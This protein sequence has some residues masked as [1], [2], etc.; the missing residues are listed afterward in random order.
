MR[1]YIRGNML[2]ITS[3]DLTNCD[4][5][6][7]IGLGAHLGDLWYPTSADVSEPMVARRNGHRLDTLA[8]RM[9]VNSGFPGVWDG[10]AWNYCTN[11]VDCFMQG[12]LDRRRETK[13][14]NLKIT[15]TTCPPNF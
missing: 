6:G 13:I 7:K 1:G 2:K 8:K 14:R 15:D 12:H 10:Y 9:S 3:G 5:Y 4:I 11:S